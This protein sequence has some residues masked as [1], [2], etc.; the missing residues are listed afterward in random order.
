MMGKWWKA[1][2]L[3]E[4]IDA[5]RFDY[6]ERGQI[7]NQYLFYNSITFYRPVWTYFAEKKGAKIISYFYSTSE[8]I[9]LLQVVLK[10]ILT[11]LN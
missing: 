10:K 3:N 11:T 6:V 2:L 4:F 5:K 9:M 1:M 7:A 8:S